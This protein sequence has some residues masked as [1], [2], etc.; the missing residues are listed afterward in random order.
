M[1]YFAYGWR[2]MQDRC[3]S[4]RFFGVALLLDHKLAFTRKSIKRGCG[5]AD[6]LATQGQ[7]VW[8][9]VYEID[10]R[11]IATLDASEGYK[12][13]RKKNSYFRR[14]CVV[15][16]DGNDQQQLTAFTYFADPIPNPPLP[17]IE[18]KNLG[19]FPDFTGKGRFASRTASRDRC[20]LANIGHDHTTR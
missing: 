3:P 7:N 1:L 17:N 9:V 19:P 4:A 16:L 5:V 8:G 6:I 18:Y 15:L 20:D 10:A 2:Q 13:G 12:L 14:E 11:D